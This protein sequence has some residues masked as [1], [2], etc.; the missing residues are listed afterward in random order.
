MPHSKRTA[1][2]VQNDKHTHGHMIQDEQK[3]VKMAF[4]SIFKVQFTFPE[5]R[6]GFFTAFGRGFILTFF[7]FRH[8]IL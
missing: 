8:Y 1:D 7:L 6:D 4:K 3:I 5:Q 2:K